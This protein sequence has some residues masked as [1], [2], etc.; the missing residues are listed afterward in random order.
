[1]SATETIVVVGGGQAG[2]WAAK[3]LR[4]EGF[5]GRIVLVGEEQHP[6]HERPPLSKAVLAGAATPESTHIF[7]PDAFS[8]LNVDLRRGESVAAIDRTFKSITLGSGESLHYDKLILCTGGLARTLAVPGIDLPGVFTLRTIADALAIG[9]ALEGTGKRLVV[10]GG[11]WIGLEV[12]AT[13]RKRGALVTVVEAMSRLCERTVPAEISAHLLALHARN[14]VE[15]TLNASLAGIAQGRAGD[16][17]V[18]LA[19]GREL[20]ADVVVV[21]VG[22]IANDALARAAGIICENGI[23]VDEQCR[24][25]DL[26]IY[27]AGDV[28]V[29]P[30]RWT[31]RRM[32]L[33]SW[34]NAQDQ[35][36]AAAKSALGREVRYEPLP[37]FWSDQ[38]D[39]N[40]QI[41]GLPAAAH[42]VVIRGDPA[43]GSFLAFY[44]DG[45]HIKA[46]VAANA[47]RDLRFARRLIEQEKSV[48]DEALADTSVALA[49]I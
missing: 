13:A 25:S 18:R 29:A 19:D 36:I 42:R 38:F 16:L 12:A 39:L 3:T 11:G 21:G 20:A 49:K 24:T 35:A 6:P 4:D 9:S 45:D 2:G 1:M 14:G 48:R 23:L 33:E 26:D 15:V 17:V 8:S 32:R 27:A 46:A 28:A 34:Q 30:N 41:Y 40:L 47:A 31:G 44:L 5:T 22:L 7:K 10:I 43:S 37:W